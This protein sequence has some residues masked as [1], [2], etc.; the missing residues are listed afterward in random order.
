M[1][2]ILC[3]VWD[4]LQNNLTKLGWVGSIDEKQGCHKWVTVEVGCWV[5]MGLLYYSIFIYV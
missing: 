1:I 4:L 3:N 2:M 5:H